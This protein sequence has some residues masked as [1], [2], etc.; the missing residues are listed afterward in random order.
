MMDV[1]GLFRKL[2]VKDTTDWLMLPYGARGLFLQLWR[3]AD[4]D[5]MVELGK[6]GLRGI[7]VHVGTL[8]DWERI[9]PDLKDLIDSGGAIHH[10]DSGH[11]ELASFVESQGAYVQNPEAQ[12]KREKRRIAQ[13]EK[14]R[15][16]DNQSPDTSGHVRTDHGHVETRPIREEKRRESEEIENRTPTGINTPARTQ[17]ATPKE[18][19]GRAEVSTHRRSDTHAPSCGPDGQGSKPDEENCADPADSLPSRR[20]NEASSQDR[21][22]APVVEARGS[23]VFHAAP[24]RPG[25]VEPLSLVSPT[26]AP[27]KASILR[28]TAIPLLAYLSQARRRIKPACRDLEPLPPNLKHI[29]ARLRDGFTA[30]QLRH[31]V[32]VW[33]SKARGDPANFQ[34]FNPVTPFRES[35]IAQYLAMDV[36]DAGK[37]FTG[38]G[39]Q[40]NWFLESL[41]AE[42]GQG[43]VEEIEI[44]ACGDE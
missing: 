42:Q 41:K 27:D 44:S 21:N 34:Y 12:R 43:H 38:N 33:E 7:C 15:D 6:H 10:Q 16:R 9:E 26:K 29:E 14:A 40:T 4:D 32:D 11:L 8:S 22:A 1:T 37:A 3:K 25:S 13:A 30:D 20:A 31:V 28:A 18:P 19:H 5:G 2:P 17:A 39:R 24:V 23:S 36:A 35:N